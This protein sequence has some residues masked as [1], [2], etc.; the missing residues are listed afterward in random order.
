MGAGALAQDDPGSVFPQ[1]AY[2]A[3]QFV[4]FIGLSAGVFE[5]SSK[6]PPEYFFDLGVRHY[7]TVLKNSRMRW[8]KKRKDVDAGILKL[9]NQPN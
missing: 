8:G 7:R 5:N 6:Y 4:D 1:P 9:L 2:R 3:D